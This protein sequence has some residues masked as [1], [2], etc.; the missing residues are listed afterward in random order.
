MVL[1]S[2][3]CLFLHYSALNRSRILILASSFRTLL[4]CIIPASVLDCKKS[5]NEHDGHEEKLKSSF[6]IFDL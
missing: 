5:M 6:S 3:L 1:G 2:G 4:G